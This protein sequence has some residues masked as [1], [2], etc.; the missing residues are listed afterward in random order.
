[1]PENDGSEADPADPPD[2]L[3]DLFDLSEADQEPT[4]SPERR[5][6]TDG[7]R[8]TTGI[9]ALDRYLAG[10][11][12][13]GRMITFMA[14]ADTQGELIV[15]QLAAEHDSLYLSS[16]RPQWEVEEA[17]RDHVQRSGRLQSNGVETRVEQ[18]DPDDRLSDARRLVDQLDRQSVLVQDA[19]DE[20]EAAGEDDYTDFLTYLKR[21][22][23]D[24]GSVGL[25]HCIERDD[26][27]PCRPVTLRLA[28]IVL[29][30][31]RS[32]RP[33]SVEYHLVVAK[34]RGGNAFPEPIKLELTD[35]IRIDTSRDIA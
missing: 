14:P 1:M 13:P 4:D 24:T 20:L 5:P 27:P 23:W 30:L 35:E 16:L 6:P 34:Y 33:G 3:D 9:E 15:K 26:P 19:V 8:L 22:L 12:P 11:I 32:V 29:E 10:G 21:R 28:D 17:V 2:T 31:R 7:N 25:L 18:L